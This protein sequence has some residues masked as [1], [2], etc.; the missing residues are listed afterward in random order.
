MKFY[1]LTVAL[2]LTSSFTIA[3]VTVTKNI[4]YIE[5]F[6]YENN[7]DLLDI[8]MPE[9]P[10]DI[11]VVIYF[12]GGAL[13]NGDKGNGKDIGYLLAKSGVGM[14]SANYRLSPDFHHPAHVKDAT[15]ATAWVINNIKK[16]GGNP[17]KVYVSGHSAGAYLAALIAIDSS[18][19]Q[20][21]NID[22]SKIAGA[23]LISPFLF[24]EETAKDR[25]QQ[26]SINRTIWG[27][28]P[29]NWMQASVT[30]HLSATRN[31]V[32]LIYA[33]GDENWRKDQNNRFALALT[34]A[35]NHRIFTKEVPNRDHS[36]LLSAILGD[37][38]EIINL[39]RDFVS[40]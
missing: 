9:N 5:D 6:I 29:Q 23:V 39:I 34:D 33:D 1:C 3:Q 40:N 28:D 13:L 26:D 22:D 20:V 10:K 16:Y 7:K 2:L 18:L 38:D 30:P 36:S 8:Y 19:L 21:H 27:S 32:L 24:V 14:V 11:P 17:E 31:N 15:A 4:D 35:G 25:V 37:D 12:H